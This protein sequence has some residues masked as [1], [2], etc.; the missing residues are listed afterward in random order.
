MSMQSI[1]KDPGWSSIAVEKVIYKFVA[2]DESSRVGVEAN[3][4]LVKIMAKLRDER[5]VPEVGSVL[6]DIEEEEKEWAIIRYS[7]KLA[8]AFG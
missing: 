4:M 8:V 1:K 5:Y 6:H 3:R 7:G 2:S